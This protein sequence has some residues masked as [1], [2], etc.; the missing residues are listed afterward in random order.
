VQQ[1]ADALGLHANTVRFHLARLARDGLVREGR[2]EDGGPGRP[3]LTYRPV[4]SGAPGGSAGPDGPGEVG[5]YRLLAQILAGHLAA[6]S[7]NASRDAI[8]AGLE[9]GRHIVERPAPFSTVSAEEGF[10]KIVGVMDALGFETERG[11]EPGKDPTVLRITYCPFRTVAQERPDVAC[12]VHLGLIRGALRE[13]GAPL[14]ATGLKVSHSLTAPCLTHFEVTG[15]EASRPPHPQAPEP[16]IGDPRT[17]TPPNGAQRPP[18]A[19]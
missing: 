18:S 1:L 2:S 15:E 5:G 12:S 8:A 10:G 13:I 11:T 4:P 17:V 19:A 9:W 14:L 6:T 16:R 3:K 7:D